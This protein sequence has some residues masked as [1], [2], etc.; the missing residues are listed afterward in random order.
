MA[1]LRGEIISGRRGGMLLK[2]DN[3]LFKRNK[4]HNTTIHWE[5]QDDNCNVRV[6]SK[7]NDASLL[8]AAPGQHI[9]D[10]GNVYEEIDYLSVRNAAVTAVQQDQCL[11]CW[12]VLSTI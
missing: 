11:L 2:F 10:H 3:N 9:H 7:T 4:T 12:K 5:C 8:L 6:L 1:Q